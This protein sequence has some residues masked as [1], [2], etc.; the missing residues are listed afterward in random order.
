M[1]VLEFVDL[2]DGRSRIDGQSVFLSVEERDEMLGGMDGGMDENFDRLE[3]LLA[4]A[5]TPV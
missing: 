2:P 3:E 5:K 1:E 4:D